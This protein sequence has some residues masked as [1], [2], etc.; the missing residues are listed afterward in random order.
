MTFSRFILF[1]CLPLI[2]FAGPVTA[3]QQ[4]SNQQQQA[5]NQFPN[6]QQ[7][8]GAQ[9]N[10]VQGNQANAAQI[11]GNQQLVPA[12][13]SPQRPFPE[14]TPEHVQYIDRVLDLWQQS[15]GQVKRYTCDYRRWDYDPLLC[16]ERDPRDN[17]LFA[18]T[19]SDGTLRYAAPDKG[20]F[21]TTRVYDFTKEEGQAPD[22]KERKNTQLNHEKW[23]CDG[24]AIYEFDYKTKYLYETPIPAE[25]QGQGMVNSPL[26]FLFGVEKEVIKNRYWLRVITPQQVQETDIWLEAYPKHINDAR[27]YQ[28]L[29]I[30]LSRN[31]WMPKVLHVYLVNYDERTNPASRVFEF[32]NRK[33]NSQLDKL[34][35]IMG[36]FVRPQTPLGWKR[37]ERTVLADGET[38]PPVSLGQNP[39]QNNNGNGNNQGFPRR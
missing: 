29:E 10:Q 28:R 32:G 38:R 24:Q 37:T 16:N 18:H 15:S 20:M 26:P 7:R 39:A 34:K 12:A 25:L 2:G 9:G 19:I 3:Q 33:I 5:G 31:D 22:Y 11:N 27:N 6:Q 14:L 21:E 35:D 4:F 8:L 13:R 1:C 17:R 30:H 36:F 23:I